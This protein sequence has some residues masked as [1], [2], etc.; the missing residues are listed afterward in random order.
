MI[1]IKLAVLLFLLFGIFEFFVLSAL[2]VVGENKKRMDR[3]DALDGKVEEVIEA[4]IDY[5]YV[6]ASRSDGDYDLNVYKEGTRKI[7]EILKEM[8]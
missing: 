6:E 2:V 3:M 5:G 7:R 4:A 1:S 8:L